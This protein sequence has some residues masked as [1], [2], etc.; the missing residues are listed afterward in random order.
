MCDIYTNF[1]FTIAAFRAAS[2]HDLLEKYRG[3]V[4][5]YTGRALTVSSDRLPASTGVHTRIADR[6]GDE[7]IFGLRKRRAAKDLF[8]IVHHGLA[9]SR[10]APPARAPT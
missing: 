6:T 3:L 5:V 1:A 7:N 10:K 8:W 2:A 4:E 9:W